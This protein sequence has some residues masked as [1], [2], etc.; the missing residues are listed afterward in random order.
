MRTG[1]IF[2]I[3]IG[4][5]ADVINIARKA[6]EV[7]N[8]WNVHHSEDKGIVLVPHHWSSSSYPSL[9]SNSAQGVINSQL[10]D[11]CDALVA[12]FGSKLGTPTKNH[13]SG[14]A[15]EI[16]EVR[17]AGKEVMV[18]FSK[19]V[20]TEVAGIDQI[21]KLDEYKKSIEGLYESFQDL[22]DFERIF[23]QKLNLFIQ[24]EFQPLVT[25]NVSNS[26]GKE[27]VSFSEEE[28]EILRNWCNSSIDYCSQ[29]AFIGG[30]HMF[31]FGPVQ[32]NTETPKEAAKYN[33]FVKRLEAVGF[34]EFQKFDS[35]GKPRYT[36]TLEAYERF[37]ED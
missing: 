5:P 8:L 22:S 15:E 25:E 9:K 35:R 27:T 31:R 4:S 16:A 28:I 24:N 1:Y 13:P 3:M 19:Q 12:I 37:R 11:K 17:K 20:D 36:L 29:I 7:I 10:V 30:H 14:T 2:N 26:K 32:V 18:F 23:T 6:I 34:I 33:E 21:S